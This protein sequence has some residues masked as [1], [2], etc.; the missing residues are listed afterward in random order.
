MVLK[1]EHV[2][3]MRMSCFARTVVVTVFQQDKVL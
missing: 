2:K 3:F 1:R